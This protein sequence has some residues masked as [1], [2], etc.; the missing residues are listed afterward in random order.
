MTPKTM[1]KT[2]LGYFAAF[3]VLLGMEICIGLFVDDGFVRP[4]VG[5][6]LVTALLCCLC[7]V[8]WPRLWPVIPVFALSCAVEGLQAVKIMEI[9]GLQGTVL[10][11]MLGIT[12]D[13]KDL[14]CY[15]AGCLTFAAGEYVWRKLYVQ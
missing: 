1:M 11:V 2:R 15:G 3:V 9:M 4:Y 6:V 14:I 7:R 13:W 12:F 5:D 8:V 10:A